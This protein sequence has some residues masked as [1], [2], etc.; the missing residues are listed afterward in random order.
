MSLTN[1]F[2][3]VENSHYEL[4][5]HLIIVRKGLFRASVVKTDL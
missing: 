3:V 5:E 2:V 4:V 1:N